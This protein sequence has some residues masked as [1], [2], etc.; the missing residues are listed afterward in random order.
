M[1]ALLL[2]LNAIGQIKDNES[3]VSGNTQLEIR[4]KDPVEV[5]ELIVKDQDELVHLSN[6]FKDKAYQH[7]ENLTGF[8]IR[9][10]GSSGVVKTVAY[11]K[12][13]FASLNLQTKVDTFRFQSWER[14][15]RTTLPGGSN[16]PGK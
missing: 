11:L 13:Y 16:I 4:Q 9:N 8:G 3:L 10:A 7:A 14:S 5:H 2:C 12:D 6:D 15:E 1:V